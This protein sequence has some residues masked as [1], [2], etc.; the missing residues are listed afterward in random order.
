VNEGHE[1]EDRLFDEQDW[2]N[3]DSSKVLYYARSKT[4]AEQE[5]WE[6]VKQ[7]SKSKD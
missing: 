6:F 4:I 5:A 2:T 1:D 7:N 3:L